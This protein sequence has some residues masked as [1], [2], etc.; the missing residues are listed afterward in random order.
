MVTVSST[1]AIFVCKKRRSYFGQPTQEGIAHAIPLI[2]S[3]LRLATQPQ[4]GVYEGVQPLL[5][6]AKRPILVAASSCIAIPRLP[7]DNSSMRTHP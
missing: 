6:V 1:S 2:S 7:P 3:L 4:T 5:G